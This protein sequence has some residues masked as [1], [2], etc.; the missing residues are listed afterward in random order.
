MTEN[1]RPA[2]PGLR[3][4]DAGETLRSPEISPSITLGSVRYALSREI[5]TVNTSW[6][7]LERSKRTTLERKRQA[8]VQAG[9]SEQIQAARAVFTF[10]GDTIDSNA[11]SAML[12]TFRKMDRDQNDQSTSRAFS[13]R[14]AALGQTMDTPGGDVTQIEEAYIALEVAV[15]PGEN[16]QSLENAYRSLNPQVT[17]A[18]EQR[19]RIRSGILTMQQSILD[20]IIRDE[21]LRLQAQKGATP[22]VG[23][24]KTI[25]LAMPAS[26]VLKK[27]AEEIHAAHPTARYTYMDLLTRFTTK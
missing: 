23:S 16:Q 14:L 15:S 24:F 7:V 17:D 13:A 26:D 21:V 22:E 4:V 3:P 20:D 6:A 25:A 8:K 11:F 18:L 12:L 27:L 19:H 10:E 2:P 9:E 5:M 1:R